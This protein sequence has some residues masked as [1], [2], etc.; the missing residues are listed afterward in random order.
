MNIDYERAIVLLDFVESASKH[1]AE[2]NFLVG[3][4][5][6]ELKAMSDEVAEEKKAE[7][8]AKAEA[9]AAKAA[10]DARRAAHK[11]PEPEKHSFTPTSPPVEELSR[12]EI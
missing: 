10:A 8:K 4:A 3:E 9:D 1:G 6:A 11:T 2:Y 12:R 7:A 5:R